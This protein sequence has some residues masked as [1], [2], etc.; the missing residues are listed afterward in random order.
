MKELTIKDFQKILADFEKEYW[1]APKGMDEQTRHVTLHLT[2]L[3]GKI[4]G[5]CEK[6]EHGFDTD[7]DIIKREVIPDLFYYALSLSEIYNVDLEKAFLERLETN[8][9]KVSGWKKR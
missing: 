7:T 8:R 1:V 4:G 6:R 3:L 2:K 9:K 5:V